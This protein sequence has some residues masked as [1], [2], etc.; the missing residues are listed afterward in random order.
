M[1]KFTGIRVKLHNVRL[2]FP[3]L[4]VPKPFEEGQEPSYDCS[5]LLDPKNP[6]HV[7]AINQLKAEV[8]RG[9]KEVF[10]TKPANWK[11][12]EFMAKGETKVSQKTGLPYDGYTGMVVVA[13][14]NKKRPALKGRDGVDLTPDEVSRI[15]YGG[16]YVNAIVSVWIQDNKY[17]KTARLNLD[18]VKFH[19]DGEA[20][21]GGGLADDEWDDFGDDDAGGA[22]FGDDD[23]A[24]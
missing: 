2:S 22:D 1:G 18:G 14:K 21:G 12:I 19:A 3:T 15:M 6:K 24:F 9:I 7:E 10:G 11:P 5:F 17:G 8:E 23:I 16:C 4:A 13:A 20:F